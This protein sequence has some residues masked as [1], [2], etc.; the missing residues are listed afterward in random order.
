M[1]PDVELLLLAISAPPPASNA[2]PMIV[3]AIPDTSIADRWG[4]LGGVLEGAASGPGGTAGGGL[5]TG[6][7]RAADATGIAAGGSAD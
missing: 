2:A 1:G 7:G 6:A 3:T 4:T 5:A